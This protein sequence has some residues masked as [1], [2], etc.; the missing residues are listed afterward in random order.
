[1][2]LRVLTT[3]LAWLL[4]ALSAASCVDQG[5]GVLTSDQLIIPDCASEGTWQPFELALPFL[6]VVRSGE[7]VLLRLSKTSQL[8]ELTDSLLIH[9]HDYEGVTTALQAS[10]EARLEVASGEVSIGLSM[11][12]SCPDSFAALEA[13]GG[14]VSFT[15]L[16]TLTGD[17]I[18]ATFE[19]TLEDRRSGEPVGAVFS[20]SIAHEVLAGTPYENFSDVARQHG[21]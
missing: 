7:V 12:G 17:M 2:R 18:V 10:G 11:L 19:F 4:V 8:T 13:D 15:R 21:E 16:G 6:G 1:M 20:G 14:W 3:L 5:P 9:V